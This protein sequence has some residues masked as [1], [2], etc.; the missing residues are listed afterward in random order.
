MIMNATSN[1]E[2][3]PTRHEI[4][5]K[6]YQLWEQ[7]GHKTGQ[8]AQYWLQAEKELCTASQSNAFAAGAP[9]PPTEIPWTGRHRN[10]TRIQH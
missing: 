3:K 1:K 9:T 4:E 8:D 7:D 6:A 5:V 2:P 10:R